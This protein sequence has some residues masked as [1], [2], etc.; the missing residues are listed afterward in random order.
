[1]A[2]QE[3]KFKRLADVELIDEAPDTAHALAEIDGEIKR[4]AGGIGGGGAGGY[5]VDA[6]AEGAFVLATD[7]STP[8]ITVTVPVPGLL[9]ALEKGCTVTLKGD[10]G[11]AFGEAAS[12]YYGYMVCENIANFYDYMMGS[13]GSIDEETTPD[14]IEMVKKLFVATA[15]LLGDLALVIFTNGQDISSIMSLSATPAALKLK[16]L[17]GGNAVAE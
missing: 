16:G 1:M 10:L 5:L 11:I 13:G 6:T 2:E 4:V 14:Q 9:E 17:K 7:S 8:S 12:G 3:F 15:S